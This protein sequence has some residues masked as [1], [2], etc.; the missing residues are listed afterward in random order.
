MTAFRI[1]ADQTNGVNEFV[2]EAFTGA[3]IALLA[4]L[5]AMTWA[6]AL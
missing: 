4:V 1:A 6:V 3:T 5:A 2:T